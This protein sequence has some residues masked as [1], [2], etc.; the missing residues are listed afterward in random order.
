MCTYLH[1]PHLQAGSLEFLVVKISL[2][3]LCLLM[4]GI[5]HIHTTKASQ[6]LESHILTIC[7]EHCLEFGL[8]AIKNTSYST[9][10]GIQAVDNREYMYMYIII[11]QYGRVTSTLTHVVK[12]Y[13]VHLSLTCY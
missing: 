8:C 7:P 13:I 4:R 2:G 1:G 6:V 5:G 11:N 10:T 3:K 9:D 12:T